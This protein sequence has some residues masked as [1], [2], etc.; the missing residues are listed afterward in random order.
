MQVPDDISSLSEMHQV[1]IMVTRNWLQTIILKIAMS[2]YELIFNSS[3]DFMPLL[4]PIDVLKKTLAITTRASP[5]SIAVSDSCI[6]LKLIEILDT[7]SDVINVV[8]FPSNHETIDEIY[9]FIAM[10]ILILDIPGVSSVKRQKI[11][12]KLDLIGAGT[13]S[14][15]VAET[16]SNISSPKHGRWTFAKQSFSVTNVMDPVSPG[17]Y[18]L[19]FTDNLIL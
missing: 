18:Q 7:V 13:K 19:D 6:V 10:A 2:K 12:E 3:K 17:Q 16:S 11:K 15:L 4:F 1:D 9:N 14:I 5:Y 8:I